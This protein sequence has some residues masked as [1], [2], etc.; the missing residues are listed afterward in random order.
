MKWKIVKTP[1]FIKEKVCRKETMG[2]LE[3]ILD[4]SEVD[5]LQEMEAKK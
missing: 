5:L 3:E 2:F 4:E 1:S